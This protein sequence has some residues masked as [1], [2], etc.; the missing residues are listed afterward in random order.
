MWEV[1]LTW[2]EWRAVI[3]LLRAKGL[4]YMLDH[5]N[6]IERQLDQHAPDEQIVRLILTDD[7]FLRSFNWAR[8]QLGIP[9]P[10]PR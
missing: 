8:L 3:D 9:L 4:A 1:D 10:P 2:E 6:R 5:A 7:V